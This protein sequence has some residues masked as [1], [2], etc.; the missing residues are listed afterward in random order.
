MVIPLTHHKNGGFTELKVV[1][2]YLSPAT[3]GGKIYNAQLSFCLQH[4]QLVC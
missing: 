1:G 4:F 3:G 2:V